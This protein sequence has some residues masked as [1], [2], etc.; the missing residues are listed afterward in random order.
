MRIQ[1]GIG[2]T[3]DSSSKGFTLDTSDPFP[4]ST[5]VATQN[6][7][8]FKVINVNEATDGEATIVSYEILPGTF[9]NVM[10]QVFNT[11]TEEWEYLDDLTADYKLLLEFDGTTSSIVYLRVGKDST[12]GAFPPT[13]PAG[14]E[15]DPYP[16]IYTTGTTLPADTDEFG[17]LQI[18]KVVELSAGA[19]RVDQY[20]T[21]SL[22]GNRIKLGSA[23]A[24]YFYARI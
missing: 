13:T 15:D 9:N 17:Y 10:P 14:G 12:T 11:I 23:T 19:Y 4:P 22:W 5:F 6:T 24:R 2:Y 1:P 18:A 16:R 3:F 8:P 7:H 20:V 21:G